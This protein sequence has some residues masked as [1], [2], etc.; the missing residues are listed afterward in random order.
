VLEVLEDVAVERREQAEL[1]EH[2]L[3]TF[4]GPGGLPLVE[5]RQLVFDPRDFGV[6]RRVA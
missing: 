5:T 6:G 4:I 1:L 3:L 2:L